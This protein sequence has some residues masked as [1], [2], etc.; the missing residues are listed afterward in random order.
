ME[1]VARFHAL[2]DGVFHLINRTLE[3]PLFDRL[4]PIL[5]DKWIAFALAAVLIG[6]LIARGGRQ[7]WFLVGLVVAAVA[8]SDSSANLLKHLLERTRPC[9]VLPDVHLLTGCTR[10]SSLPS[11]HA[12]NMFALA[13]VVW[14]TLPP[15]RW[16]MIVLAAAVSYSR[17]YLGVHYP[18]D[19]LVGAL[20]GSCVG[21]SV[22]QTAIHL[23]PG[24][25]RPAQAASA[26]SAQDA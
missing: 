13:A 4:M 1:L 26:S 19:V 3:N 6:I 11:N 17:I 20:W 25:F 7:G 15:W 23:W 24:L 8:L 14:L 9:H 5:S 2:D 21:W 16:S 10:S 18:S 12:S 22:A